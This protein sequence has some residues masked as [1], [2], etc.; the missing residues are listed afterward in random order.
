MD[1]IYFLTIIKTL[2]NIT[3]S[4]NN[5]NIIKLLFY[6][7]RTCI[8]VCIDNKYSYNNKADYNKYFSILIETKD[9]I[10]FNKAFIDYLIR[11]VQVILTN[12]IDEIEFNDNQNKLLNVY[13]I[14]LI[15]NDYTEE[16]LEQIKNLND[17]KKENDLEIIISKSNLGILCFNELRKD[18]L[19][20]L[21]LMKYIFSIKKFNQLIKYLDKYNGCLPIFE[22]DINCVNIDIFITDALNK[23]KTEELLDIKQK[24]LNTGLFS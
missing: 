14:H 2:S 9:C 17:E 15:K 19:F 7:L 1:N 23:I 20:F 12:N 21:R 3:N 18:F 24:V 5:Q 16:Q 4:K 10:T 6:I 8:Q 13:L 11:L 22:D